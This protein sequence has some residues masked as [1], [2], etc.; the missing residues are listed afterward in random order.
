MSEQPSFKNPF[1]GDSF[2]GPLNTQAFQA[3]SQAQS[4]LLENTET[5]VKGWLDRNR[6]AADATTSALRKMSESKDPAEMAR[7]WADLT[8]AQMQRATEGAGAMVGQYMTMWQKL[9]DSARQACTPDTASS[10]EEP[11]QIKVRRA[12]G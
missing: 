7:I 2:A 4:T 12:A 8:S 10:T 11:P 9:A 3:W 5:L 6:E 1:L